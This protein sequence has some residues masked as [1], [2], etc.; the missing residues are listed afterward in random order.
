MSTYEWTTPTAGESRYY[1]N[2]V[3]ITASTTGEPVLLAW[4]DGTKTTLG[5][6][7]ANQLDDLVTTA[8]TQDWP[9]V[10][11]LWP[12]DTWPREVYAGV[13]AG[14]HDCAPDLRVI[15]DAEIADQAEEN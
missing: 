4:V 13:K 12:R 8:S 11:K 10:E 2:P 1:D 5:A 9:A 14:E 6:S 3:A 7:P 15:L